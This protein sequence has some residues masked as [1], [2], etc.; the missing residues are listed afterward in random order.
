VLSLGSATGTL[1]NQTTN[2]TITSVDTTK[3]YVNFEGIEVDAVSGAGGSFS[4]LVAKCQLTSATNVEVIASCVTS[5][6]N[7]N[8]TTTIK[9]WYSV[10]EWN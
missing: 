9:V 10:V 6:N 2:Q 3:A 8:V 7:A 1:I 5:G 4:G